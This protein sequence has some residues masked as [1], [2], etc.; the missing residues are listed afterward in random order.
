MRPYKAK[1]KRIIHR[2]PKGRFRRST[3]SDVGMAECEKCGSL[4]VPNFDFSGPF[5]DPREM[6]ERRRFCPNCG[7]KGE[8]AGKGNP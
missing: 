3:L 6:R 4:F 2:G 7:G 8:L 5:I 1:N